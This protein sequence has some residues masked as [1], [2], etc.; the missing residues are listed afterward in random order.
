MLFPHRRG[1]CFPHHII[2]QENRLVDKYSEQVLLPYMHVL[3]KSVWMSYY[4]ADKLM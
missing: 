3:V 1:E 2:N 4:G